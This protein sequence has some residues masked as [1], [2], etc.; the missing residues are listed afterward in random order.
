MKKIIFIF[1][2]SISF[3]QAQEIKESKIELTFSCGLSFL[4]DS[5][6]EQLSSGIYFEYPRVGS[7]I[8]TNLDFRIPKNRFIGIGFARQNHLKEQY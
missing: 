4:T 2:L 8:A 7:F 5:Q 3:L 1:L 6:Q